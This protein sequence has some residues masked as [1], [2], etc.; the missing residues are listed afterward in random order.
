MARMTDVHLTDDGRSA[1]VGGGIK[2]KKLVQDLWDLGKQSGTNVFM[3]L[4]DG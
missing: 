2:S 4:F 3:H 1:T